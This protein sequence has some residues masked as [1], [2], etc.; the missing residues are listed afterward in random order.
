MQSICRAV[1]SIAVAEPDLQVVWSVHPGVRGQVTRHLDGADNIRLIDPQP[2]ESFVELLASSRLVLTDSGGIQE[3]ATA[4][5]LPVLILRDRTERPE[6]LSAGNGILVGTDEQAIVSTALRL[7]DHP[8]EYRRHAKRSRIFGDGK[9][10]ERIARDLVG[11]IG[12][13]HK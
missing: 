8:T 13:H 2:Y 5:G 7:L 3:E 12:A 6:V 11:Q 4:L 1:R 10:G 9:A